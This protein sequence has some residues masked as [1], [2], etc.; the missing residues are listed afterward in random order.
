MAS[1]QVLQAVALD[2]MQ[3]SLSRSHALSRAWFLVICSRING[4][5]VSNHGRSV[6]LESDSREQH[7][8]G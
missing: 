5:N 8:I 7:G 6:I 1:A 2:G 4:K 3:Q